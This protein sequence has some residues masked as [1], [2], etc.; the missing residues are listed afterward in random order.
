MIN[1]SILEFLNLSLIILEFLKELKISYQQ[2]L[3]LQ[4][5]EEYAAPVKAHMA[6]NHKQKHDLRPSIFYLQTLNIV[7]PKAH[8]GVTTKN[9]TN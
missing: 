1:K 8:N 2:S 6:P 9:I 3:F 4:F 5:I 7:I